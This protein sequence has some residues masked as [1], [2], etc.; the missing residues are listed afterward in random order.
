MLSAFFGAIGQKRKGEPLRMDWN[1]IIGKVGVCKVGSREY[2]GNKYNEVKGMIYAED[3]DYTKVL[4]AQPGQYQQQPAPQ[5]QQQPQ[6]PA[7][8]QGGF[9]G[10]PF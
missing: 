1:A 2:N 10:G 6:Q 4:N 3:V 9:T 5:Y 7:Q 8:P